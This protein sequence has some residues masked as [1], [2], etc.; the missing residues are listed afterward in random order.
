M[1]PLA[2]TLLCNTGWGCGGSCSSSSAFGASV[3]VLQHHTRLWQPR[4]F[5][6]RG[7]LIILLFRWFHSWPEQVVGLDD[8]LS[9]LPSRT[10]YSII[11]YLCAEITFF[12]ECKTLTQNPGLAFQYVLRN[13]LT[14]N[15]R[16]TRYS[17]DHSIRARLTNPL[18][19]RGASSSQHP[20]SAL[21]R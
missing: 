15:Y 21:T 19:L 3:H 17:A 8:L 14:A 1:D 4:R 2:H 18:E 11:L 6:Y 20:K 5:S 7:Y 9:S 12:K 10:I 13:C 16:G